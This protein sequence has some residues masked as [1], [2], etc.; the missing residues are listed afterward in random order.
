M[1]K[2]NAYQRLELAKLLM[3]AGL[4]TSTDEY[5]EIL[6]LGHFKDSE[7]TKLIKSYFGVNE[8]EV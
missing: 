3:E 7:Q 4:I 1:K 8:D 5:L 2:L 6:E